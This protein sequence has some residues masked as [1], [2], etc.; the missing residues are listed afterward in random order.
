[1]LRARD[2]SLDALPD[3]PD[4]VSRNTPEVGFELLNRAHEPHCPFGNHVLHGEAP[5]LEPVG[6]VNHQPEVCLN[7]ALLRQCITGGAQGTYRRLFLRRQPRYLANAANVMFQ[8]QFHTELSY[9][10]T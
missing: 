6:D 8:T 2:R 5:V 1:M 4:C 7:H 9:N 3:P 10:A